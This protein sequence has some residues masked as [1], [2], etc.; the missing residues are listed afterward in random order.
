MA[1][2][3]AGPI[4]IEVAAGKVKLSGAY[5][6][7]LGRA[8]GFLEVKAADVLEKVVADSTN[9]IDDALAAP[10]IAMLRAAE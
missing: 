5:D 8:G 10:L 2:F 7:D 4:D 3:E 1:D 9:K 6:H